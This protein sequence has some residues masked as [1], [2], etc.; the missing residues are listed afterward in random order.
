MAARDTM[1]I[2]SERD[3]THRHTGYDAHEDGIRCTPRGF[4]CILQRD[5]VNN[6]TGPDA[7]RREFVCH[8]LWKLQ[9]VTG[10]SPIR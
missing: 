10:A 2:E 7:P 9:S 3:A 1:H 4:R 5:T 6:V 8:L